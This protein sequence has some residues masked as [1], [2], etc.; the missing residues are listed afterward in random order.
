MA[1]GAA[2]KVQPT[3]PVNKSAARWLPYCVFPVLMLAALLSVRVLIAQGLAASTS[4]L[5]IVL[6]FGFIGVAV[7]ERLM[8]YRRHWLNSHQDVSADVTHLLINAGIPS[9]WTP[10]QVFLLTA[11]SVFLAERFGQGLWPESWHWSAELALMLLIAEFGRYWVHRAAHRIGWLWRLHAVHHS[12]KRLYWL[13][14]NRFHPLEKLIFQIPEVAPFILLGTPAEIIAM[15]F[16]FNAIHGLLQHS[17]IALKGGVLN[18]V[19]SLTELH[20]WHHSRLVHESDHNF[21]NNLIVWDL[22]FGT[23]YNPVGR[24]VE[25]IGLLNPDYPQ[26]YRGMLKAPFVAGDISKPPNYRQH[27]K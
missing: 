3:M 11:A 16:C 23:Y 19:F 24:E 8:P 2:P 10:V 12:P 6:L 18:W 25:T 21:G 17:N 20:R 9:L 13:N 5:I 26:T 27:D 15:Y 14:A 7:L 22:L 1:D 4:A